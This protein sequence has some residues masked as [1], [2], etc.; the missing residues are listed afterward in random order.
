M[1]DAVDVLL[2]HWHWIHPREGQV[3]AVKQQAHIA[4]V[5]FRHKAVDFL[6]GL[7]AGAHVVV[8]GELH[9]LFRSQTTQSVEALGDL[10][11]F[12]L[13]V[14]GLV[15]EDIEGL[16]LDGVAL[17]AGAD[18]PRAQ[19]VQPV[20]VA[21]EGL[22]CHLIGLGGEQGG[23]PRVADAQAAHLQ[24]VP[25]HLHILRILVADLAAREAGQRHFAH[26]L[27]KGV[28]RAQLGHIIVGPADGCD[29][30]ANLFGIQ[31][32]GKPTSLTDVSNL[33]YRG[34]AQPNP[35]MPAVPGAARIPP[36]RPRATSFHS[37]RSW[38]RAAP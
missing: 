13:G 30:Q 21:D 20:A 34:C 12:L 35:G 5:G 38:N 33:A 26:A 8:A 25:Q 22:L 4:G 11:P 9:A 37:Q 29:G 18:D 14:Y 19:G 6:H 24:L 10:L 27:L 1:L 3:A 23:E 31:F 32:H 36:P 28:L 16:A 15:T 7:H 17:L 2:Q